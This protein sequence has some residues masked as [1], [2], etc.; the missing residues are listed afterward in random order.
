MAQEHDTKTTI[1]A[2]LALGVLVLVPAVGLILTTAQVA[3][4]GL[5]WGVFVA[6]GA[7]AALV[8]LLLLEPEHP[9]GQGTE[10]GAMACVSCGR[11]MIADAR[12][13]PHCGTMLECDLSVPTRG[14]RGYV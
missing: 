3:P 14:D 9:D 5:G 4:S 13:C 7:L 8:V 6:V 11:P 1:V 12:L 2:G 10:V